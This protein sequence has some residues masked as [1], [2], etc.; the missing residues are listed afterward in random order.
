[1]PMNI[2]AVTSTASIADLTTLEPTG[3]VDPT[4]QT[5]SRPQVSERGKLLQE[6]SDLQKSDP[7]KFKKVTEEIS[8]K[9]RDAA[10]SASAGQAS[11]LNKLADRFDQA[12]QSGDMS[13]LQPADGAGGHHGGHHHVKKYASNQQGTGDGTSQQQP[14][15][16][17]AQIIESA[18]SDAN[19]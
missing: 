14:G 6:L 7:E 2:T 10:S 1:M 11:A 19:A 8:Q 15:A 5:D 12:S 9:L 16:D 3:S 4:L 17:I 13:A 18:L